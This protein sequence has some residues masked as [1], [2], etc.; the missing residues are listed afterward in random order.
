MTKKQQT[1]FLNS[2]MPWEILKT[3][4]PATMA[5]HITKGRYQIAPH[6]NILN[7]KLLDVAGG[8]IKRLIVNM[9]PRHG[10]SE[11]ISRYFP[12]WYLGT[13]PDRR[14]ILV[15]YE[16]GFAASWGRKTKELLEEHGEDLFGI[17]LNRLSNS[18]YRWDVLGQEGGL[19]ATGVGGA[20][21]GKGAN[22][23]IIDDPVK[24]DE[25]AN[26]KTYRDKTYDWFRA[27]A[28]TR[29]EPDG[30]IIVIMTRWHFDDLA[31]RLI[32]D[33]DS[34]DK[35]E[36]LS[37]PAIAKE[38]DSLGRDEGVPLWEYR[39]PVDKL[40][41]IKSQIGSYWFSALYQQQPIATEY[42]IFKTEWWKEYFDL[43]SGSLLIHRTTYCS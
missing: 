25:Q 5:M 22:V 23:L 21:T 18:A 12:A 4:S 7:K 39:Y 2:S 30:A 26:S 8:R 34:D 11:L 9:P 36:V 42:Q 14:I 17:K 41:K 27:T 6:I 10:K 43:P 20:I 3:A 16:A 40:N 19:N 15:S 35:W 33:P 29:L 37:F 1:L 24:N 32:N 31:G 13:Y 28:Y 38:N